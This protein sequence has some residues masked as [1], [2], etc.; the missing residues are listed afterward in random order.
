MEVE[1]EF[2]GRTPLA[3][4]QRIRKDWGGCISGHRASEEGLRAGEMEPGTCHAIGEKQGWHAQQGTVRTPMLH[5]PWCT[6]ILGM[7]Y[8]VR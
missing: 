8:D 5:L 6:I 7:A 1:G 4:V 2:P 3:Q